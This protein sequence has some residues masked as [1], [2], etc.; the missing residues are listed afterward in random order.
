[1]P[2]DYGSFY[3]VPSALLAVAAFFLVLVLVL[4]FAPSALLAVAAFSPVLVRVLVLVL[5]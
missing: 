1:M 2:N 4:E 3:H 5:E